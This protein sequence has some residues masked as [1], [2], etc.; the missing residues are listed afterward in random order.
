MSLGGFAFAG[1]GF[2]RAAHLRA[3]TDA[4]DAL[5]PRA[6]V[7]RLDAESRALDGPAL[8][9]WPAGAALAPERPDDAA[10]LG[11]L[12]EGACFACERPAD[13]QPTTDLRRAGMQWPALEAA[14]FATAAGLFNWRRRARHCGGCGQAVEA[15]QCGWAVHCPRCGLEAYPR[16][17]PAIIVAVTS[18]ERLLLGRQRSWPPGRWSVV[19]GFVEPG[20]TLAQAVVREVAEETGVRVEA[21][22]YADDQPWPFPLALMLGFFADAPGD[23]PDPVVGDELEDARWFSL[24]EVRAGLAASDAPG[25]AAPLA[26]APR[27]SIAR[28]LIEAWVDGRRAGAA[29]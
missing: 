5:W 14:L 27:L 13:G 3:S 12:A 29:R 1:V 10:F 4:L 20:E 6:R 23:A 11:L 28:A 8:A 15:R 19:A 9:D 7:L 17:D 22:H 2:D 18:G 16:T 21:V 24:E 26:F 25:G